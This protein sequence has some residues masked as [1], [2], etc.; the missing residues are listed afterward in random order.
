MSRILIK[1]TLLIALAALAAADPYKKI[2][3]NTDPKAKCLDGSSPAVYFHQGAEKNKFL[4]YFMGGGFCE[5]T[6]L[7]EV[8][9][10]C[11]QRSKTDYGS[12]KNLAETVE[13]QGYLSTDPAKNKFAAW[14]KVIFNYCDGAL[15]QGSTNSSYRYKDA[16]IYFRGADNVRSHLKWLTL[17][18]DLPSAE[19]VLITGSSAGGL[20]TFLW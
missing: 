8:L 15:H 5:G 6:S 2:I 14:T 10:S 20:A 4:I 18:Y 16:E 3:H 13:G 1:L 9:E 19:K 12:S 7:S 17:N 11:Y